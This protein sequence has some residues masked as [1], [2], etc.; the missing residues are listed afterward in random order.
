M[1]HAAGFPEK[2][3]NWYIFEYTRLHGDRSQTTPTFKIKVTKCLENR[4]NY[5][6]N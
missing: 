3:K 6:P 4:L 1:A 5:G 2:K